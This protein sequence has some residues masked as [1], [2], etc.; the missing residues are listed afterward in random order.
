I[1][2][3]GRMTALGRSR[4]FTGYNDRPR[5]LSPHHGARAPRV[6]NTARRSSM[7]R[8]CE[9]SVERA[10]DATQVNCVY[11]QCAVANLA[12]RPRT[13]EPPQLGMALP[14]TLSGLLLKAAERL[15]LALN[16]KQP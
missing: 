7:A 12:P 13:H 5:H 2:S 10:R 16:S 8:V 4:K 1:R 15:E 11:Q 6:G 3:V 14:C 9:H